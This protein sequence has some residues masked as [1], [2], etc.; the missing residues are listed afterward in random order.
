MLLKNIMK[1]N[2]KI[3]PVFIPHKGCKTGCYFCNQNHITG[4]EKIPDIEEI[5]KSIKLYFSYI[6]KKCEKE[7]AFYGGSFT[8]FDPEFQNNLLEIAYDMKKKGNIS[9]IRLSTR[10]DCI[11]KSVILRLKK[12]GVDIVELGIQ[13]MDDN[14]LK[15]INRG[16]NSEDVKKASSLIK[17]SGFFLGHQIMPGL[18][19][20]DFEKDIYT[21]KE[22]IKLSPDIVRIYPALVIK[23]TVFEK[24][25]IKGEYLPETE[26]SIIERVA[27]IYSMY[28]L[29]NVDVIRVGLQPT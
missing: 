12:Y 8:A 17:E 26:E 15:N 6:D 3:I 23:D 28:I 5:K 19:T 29:N 11:D 4:I 2:I 13:S 14:V 9:R 1:K 27:L 25:Y 10:P 21:A 24:L 16:H 7:I 18:Y 20:S 22:S